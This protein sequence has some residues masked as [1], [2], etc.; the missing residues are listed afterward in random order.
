MMPAMQRRLNPHDHDKLDQY[1]TG[2][3][4]IETRIQKAEKFGDPGPNHRDAGRH[5]GR[6]RGA[7]ANNV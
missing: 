5:P 6:L 4:E 1:L 3:R 2:V 7:R